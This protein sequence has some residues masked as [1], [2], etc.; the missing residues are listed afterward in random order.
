MEGK[1]AALAG[2]R[3]G[4]RLRQLARLIGCEPRLVTGP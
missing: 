3:V 1:C 4:S 2:D